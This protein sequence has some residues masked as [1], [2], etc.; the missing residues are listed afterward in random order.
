MDKLSR[1]QI[2]QNKQTMMKY[3]Q[4]YNTICNLSKEVHP[5]NPDK[6]LILNL[7]NAVESLL[8]NNIDLLD[9]IDLLRREVDELKE[10]KKSITEVFKCYS[11]DIDKEFTGE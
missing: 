2:N 10:F 8:R 5:N 1:D 7:T 6:Y 11:N 4:I 3:S 9:Q